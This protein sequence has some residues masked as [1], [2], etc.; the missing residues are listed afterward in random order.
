MDSRVADH[1][2]LGL[3]A[4]RHLRWDDAV[5]DHA[6]RD[7]VSLAVYLPMV[8]LLVPSLGNDGLWPAFLVFMGMRAITL[9]VAYPS[10]DRVLDSGG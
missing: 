5:P 4:Q 7:A 2:R 1:F 9:G 8:A 6:Q 3:P 10:V